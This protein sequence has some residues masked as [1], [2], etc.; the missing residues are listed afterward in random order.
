[1][2][3]NANQLSAK[4]SSKVHSDLCISRSTRSALSLSYIDYMVLSTA[5]EP[6]CW[7]CT[8]RDMIARCSHLEHVFLART[9]VLVSTVA[10]PA[11]L[12]A[13]SYLAF[14]SVISVSAL[15]RFV[16]WLDPFRRCLDLAPPSIFG[17]GG[18][19]PWEQANIWD[20]ILAG[21]WLVLGL[22]VLR[23]L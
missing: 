1:M 16:F 21:L 19:C 7:V 10:Q 17:T 15:K 22:L 13:G 18:T 11:V 5:I 23:K 12:I 8:D 14:H 2:P 9:P 3:L 6:R 4:L 20:S